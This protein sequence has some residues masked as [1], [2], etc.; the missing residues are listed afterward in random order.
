MSSDTESFIYTPS[1]SSTDS[2][3]RSSLWSSAWDL[4]HCPC[5]TPGYGIESYQETTN[6]PFGHRLPQDHSDFRASSRDKQRER[7]SRPKRG[8]NSYKCRKSGQTQQRTKNR[9]KKAENVRFAVRESQKEVPC[10]TR[11][12]FRRTKHQFVEWDFPRE[13]ELDPWVHDM[14][15]AMIR[16]ITV[17]HGADAFE[18]AE[19]YV[20]FGENF[21]LWCQRRIAEMRAVKENRI[22]RGEPESFKPTLWERRHDWRH[23]KGY[24]IYCGDESTTTQPTNVYDALGHAL[25]RS[26]LSPANWYQKPMRLTNASLFRPNT[27]YQWFGEFAW[28]WH[29][30]GSGCWEVGYDDYCDEGPDMFYGCFCRQSTCVPALDEKQGCSLVEWIADEGRKIFMLEETRETELQDS[31]GGAEFSE[32]E[33]SHGWDVVSVAS[34]ESWSIVDIG[35]N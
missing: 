15:D 23:Y 29:R 14:P 5:C 4:S 11:G 2:N 19:P 9:K 34:A 35:A 16:Y 13:E 6:F 32:S 17:Q 21:S 26:I 7:K 10:Y 12:F 25:L 18:S 20:E 31:D 28:A 3:D 27:D 24:D 8:C 1:T 30:N 22:R 33:A